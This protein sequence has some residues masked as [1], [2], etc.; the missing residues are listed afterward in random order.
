MLIS[1]FAHGALQG[2]LAT[3]ITRRQTA[4]STRRH[5]VCSHALHFEEKVTGDSWDKFVW[6]VT[7]NI[8]MKTSTICEVYA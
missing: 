1:V 2:M 6:S 7:H 4:F 3:P 8:A 5:G